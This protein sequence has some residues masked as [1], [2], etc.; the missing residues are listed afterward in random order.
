MRNRDECATILWLILAESRPLNLAVHQKSTVTPKPGHWL[1]RAGLFVIVFFFISLTSALAQYRFDNWTTDHGLPQNS[2]NAITQ[3]RDGYIWF[4]TNDGLVRFDGVRFTVFDQSNSH[5][6]SSYRMTGLYEDPEGTLWI[7]SQQGGLIRYRD[8]VFT[9]FTTADGLLDNQVGGI[10]GDGNGG[11]IFGTYRGWMRYR[12]GQFTSFAE[13]GNWDTLTVYVGPTGSLWTLSPSGLTQSKDGRN[14]IYPIRHE[15]RAFVSSLF[16]SR[17]GSLWIAMP[18]FALI[19][20][21]NGVVTRYTEKDGVPVGSLGTKVSQD[22]QNNIWIVTSGA[23][24]VRFRDD[25]FVTYT[26]ADGLSSN[27]LVSFFEDREGTIWVGT[28]NHGIDRLTRQFMRAYST[29]DGLAGDNLYPIYEDHN[30]D[31]WLGATDGLTRYSGGVFTPYKV[32]GGAPILWVEGLAEDREGHLWMSDDHGVAYLKDGQFIWPPEM[33]K[34]PQVSAIYQDHHGDLWFGTNGGVY[35]FKDGVLTNYTTADGLPD[36]DVKIIYEDNQGNFWFGTYGGLAQLKFDRAATAPGQPPKP[37]FS[38]YTKDNGLGSNKVRSLYQDSDGVFWIGTY[39]GGL[40]RLKDGHIT[41]YT[42]E[43][44]LFNNGVFQILED[45]RGN[46]WMSCNRGIFRVSKQQLNDFADGKISTV[47][48]VA[49]GKLDGML[50]AECNGG[51]QY[52]GIKARDGKLWFPT[53]AGV[54]VIDPSAVP[55]NDKPPALL[56]QNV[57]LDGTAA[58]FGSLVRV[59]PGQDNIE[60]TYTGLSSVKPEQVRFKYKLAGHDDGWIDVGTRRTAYFS[61]LPPGDYTF[62]VIGANSDGVW[63]TTGAS[64][65]LIVAAPFYRRWWFISASLLSLALIAFIGYRTR[66]RQL[67]R[68]QAAQEAF[69]RRLI[70]VQENDR[71][72]IA[73]ELHDGLGQS[74]VIIKNRALLALGSPD[75][76]ERVNDQVQEI[77][78]A[79][80]QAIAEMREMAYDLR[81]FQLDRLG[82]TRAIESMIKKVSGSSEIKFSSEIDRLD[83]LF[84]KES[85]INLY[86]IVQESINNI[87][88][89]SGATEARIVIKRDGQAVQI[90]IEDNGRGFTLNSDQLPARQKQGLGLTGMSERARMLGGELNV[91][92]APGQGTMI[93][94]VRIRARE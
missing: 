36:Q 1:S 5:G 63:N 64:L 76:H 32:A 39:D 20:L 92:A 37:I 12:N 89:H 27:R 62:T 31:I 69:S 19:H 24:L 78:D 34:M 80:S 22:S 43:Q 48:S 8:G 25:Q 67:K 11:L 15:P 51:R 59:A 13:P 90:Q 40:S 6:I 58:T 57:S 35:R 87:V 38:N 68:G 85:E 14:T 33:K 94:V 16:E 82:L 9:S 10:L 28:E 17:D 84:S 72:R 29:K 18:P 66:I 60:I 53:Q 7:G 44:G 91:R 47:T 50:S 61:Y 23:G 45:Q 42:V 41:T 86:R 77:S 75:D 21:K 4:T 79:T 2:V 54:V 49:F 65:R 73:S 46:F 26:T 52:G 83:K 55:V 56:I 81:P 88:R 30:G 93:S 74:L 70:E 3:T 71:R